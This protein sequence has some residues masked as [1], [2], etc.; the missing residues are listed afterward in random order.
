MA[1]KPSQFRLRD[2]TRAFKAAAAAGV[3]D[4]SVQVRC[5]NGTIITI[6]GKSDLAASVVLRPGKGRDGQL[7]QG[8]GRK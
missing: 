3:S 1:N 7:S 4:P 5:P 2:V 8:G 6:G